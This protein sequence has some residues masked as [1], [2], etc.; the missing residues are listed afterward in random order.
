MAVGRPQK[1]LNSCK[2]VGEE[3]DLCKLV[4]IEP[5]YTRY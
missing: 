1:W 4:R 2:F 3:M 5:E